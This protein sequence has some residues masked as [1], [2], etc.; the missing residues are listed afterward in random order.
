MK[1][2]ITG[3]AGYIGTTLLAKIMNETNWEIVGL[4]RLLYNG[5]ALI[6][7]I[8]NPRFTFKKGDVRD[9]ATVKDAMKD[10]DA[11]IHLAAIV[12]FPACERDPDLS[13]SINAD[14][15][16]S[17]SKA[18]PADVPLLYG[19]TGSNYGSV[20]GI[21]TEETPLNPLTL[22]ARSKALGENYVLEHQSGIAFRFA[23]AFGVSPRMRFDLLVNDFARKLF[24]DKYLVV[25]ES[26][27]MRTFIH[28]EDIAGSFI[29]ALKN[30]D[31]F[32]SNVFNVGDNKMNFSKK[33]IC[34]MVRK[35]I[36]GLVHYAD[37]GSDGDKRNYIVDYSKLNVT[38]FCCEKTMDQGINGILDALPLIQK[39]DP[40]NNA[41]T[42]R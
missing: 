39:I 7:Y 28:V 22:Y 34:E 25:Y 42:L 6:P 29:Y 1:V 5:N 18:V 13:H 38:G 41:D 26:E 36:G 12:G 20:E 40:F 31:K 19:S 17:V 11:V 21:C 4:D 16:L 3:V 33:E 27:Y 8:T 14:A 23:T 15:T 30:V 2:L 37:F 35:K 24:F 32:K 9:A 10:C